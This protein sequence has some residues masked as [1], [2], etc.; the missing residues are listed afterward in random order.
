MLTYW[1]T[2]KISN[3]FLNP[4]QRRDLIHNAKVPI[5]AKVREC[6]E[7]QRAYTIVDGHHN[8]VCGRVAAIVGWIGNASRLVTPA[9]N[10]DLHGQSRS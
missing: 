2:T 10:P 8:R 3:V 9:E 5:E 6:K 7:A 4:S 1:I